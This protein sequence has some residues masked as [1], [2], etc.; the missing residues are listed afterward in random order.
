MNIL[1]IDDHELIAEGVKKRIN[2]IFPEATCLFADNI[3]LA[4]AL[5]HQHQID[6]IICD[7]EFDKDQE[8]DGFYIIDK[9]L[10]L[11]PRAKVIALTHYNSYRIMK[12]AKSAGFMSFLNKGCSFKDFKDTLVNVY[13]HGKYES[14]S[15]KTLIKKRMRIS[16]SIFNESLKGIID[17]SKRELE[18]AIFASKT[19]DRN[20]IAKLMKIEPYTVDSHFKNIKHKLSLNSRKELAIFS[21]DFGDILKK[22]LQ[23]RDTH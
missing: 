3:R 8:H 11:E 10:E 14:Q 6:L 23:N 9:I 18:L 20:E 21:Y 15:E 16:K 19:V 4:Y 17:L 7:L 5:M 2:K 1:L 13:K 22:E 12:K